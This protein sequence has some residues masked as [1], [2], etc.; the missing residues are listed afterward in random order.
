MG[1]QTSVSWF[2][3]AVVVSM[4]GFGDSKIPSETWED[5]YNYLPAHQCP[6]NFRFYKELRICMNECGRYVLAYCKF[7]FSI[8]FHTYWHF[9]EVIMFRIVICCPN[10]IWN[11]KDNGISTVLPS[12]VKIL[13]PNEHLS[14]F[15]WECVL[16]VCIPM[17]EHSQ[18]RFLN[19]RN[20]VSPVLLT[21]SILS[22]G[23]C[24]N[25]C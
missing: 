25:M 13:F 16:K 15:L 22:V 12:D 2:A 9:N 7:F 19:C 6:V 24:L 14:E 10:K 11:L 3:S 20:I 5:N 1:L 4:H 8:Y 23:C 18:G 17:Q 21:E